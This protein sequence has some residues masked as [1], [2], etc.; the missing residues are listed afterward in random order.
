MPSIDQ[1]TLARAVSAGVLEESQAERLWAF[2]LQQGPAAGPRFDF[3]HILYYLGGMVAIGAMSLFMTR[4]WEHF[5]GWGI[6]WIAVLYMGVSLWLARWF[7]QR[8]HEVPMGIMGALTIVLVPLA[9]WG[10]QNAL[11]MWV[12]GPGARHY[13]DYHRWIDWRWISL[14][15]ATLIAGAVMLWRWRAPFLVMPVAVTLWYLSMDLAIFIAGADTHQ[16]SSSLWTFRQWFSVAFGLAMLGFALIVELRSRG[17]RDYPFWLYLFG[18]MCFWCALS[19]MESHALA[20]KLIYLT[21][22]LVLVGFGAVL[23]RRVFAV[24][25]GMG[26]AI[27]IGMIAWDYFRDSWLFPI[28]LTVIGI[29]LVFGGLWWSRHA[30][31]IGERLRALL[32][33]ELRELVEARLL[34]GE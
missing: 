2:L 11:G 19:S 32:P 3:T 30:A 22:N 15:F 9:V 20:G 29:A 21:I 34:A 13:D 33:G 6:F 17:G 8:G 25:G 7:E 16:W 18:L 12:E 23:R 5:G 31:H 24:F 27:G 10:V 4:G 26:V 1:S 28:A 14:E